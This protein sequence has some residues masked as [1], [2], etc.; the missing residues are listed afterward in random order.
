MF[1]CNCRRQG[2]PV[3]APA[4]FAA[5]A[6]VLP[7]GG[8]ALSAGTHVKRSSSLF[9]VCFSLNI[10][11]WKFSKY[12]QVE[13]ILQWTPINLPRR[14]IKLVGGHFWLCLSC[15]SGRKI[16]AVL[17][18][19]NVHT[20]CYSLINYHV[21]KVFKCLFHDIVVTYL[22]IYSKL[23]LWKFCIAECFEWLKSLL[24]LLYTT[25]KMPITITISPL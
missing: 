14:S 19:K 17:A 10:L 7:E 4:V 13:R 15:S 1:F 2:K 12:S 3:L 18:H 8:E 20:T 25:L 22:N 21:C 9:D 23:T 5:C 6:C 24:D 11:L 16:T